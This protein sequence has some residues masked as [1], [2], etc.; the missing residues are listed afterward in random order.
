[1]YSNQNCKHVQENP[2]KFL[3]I[4]C[5]KVLPRSNLMSDVGLPVLAEA[6]LGLLRFMKQFNVPVMISETGAAD[7]GDEV[8]GQW[9]TRFNYA[10]KKW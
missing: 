8:R 9:I 1:M 6:L 3:E 4:N 2:F 5:P 7:R 10:F